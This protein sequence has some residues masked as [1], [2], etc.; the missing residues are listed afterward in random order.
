MF[1]ESRN[2]FNSALPLAI[3]KYALDRKLWEVV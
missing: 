3:V 2:T 1:S